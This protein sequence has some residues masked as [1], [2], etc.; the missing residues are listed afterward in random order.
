ME[1]VAE[2]AGDG[3][4]EVWWVLSKF[5]CCLCCKDDDWHGDVD[6]TPD[7]GTHWDISVTGEAGEDAH[8][9]P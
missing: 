6:I 7:F 8:V 1:L 4:G 2:A 5:F 3:E 9:L